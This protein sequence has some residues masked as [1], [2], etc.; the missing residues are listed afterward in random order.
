M[1]TAKVEPRCL[2]CGG[3][4]EYRRFE[5]AWHLDDS[6]SIEDCSEGFFCAV[7]KF[8]WTPFI[9]DDP[10]EVNYPVETPVYEVA[11]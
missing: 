11:A 1:T 5:D 2:N 4:L 6:L 8:L 10:E 9:K 3:E 7:C